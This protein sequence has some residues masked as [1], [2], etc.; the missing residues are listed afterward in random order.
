MVNDFPSLIPMIINIAKKAGSMIMPYFGNRTQ[1]EIRHKADNT[2]ITKADIISH[3]TVLKG[4]KKITPNI[5]LLSEEGDLPN[6]SV[7]KIWDEYW[8]CDPLDGTQG[9]LR[10]CEEFSVNIAL[11]QNH[12]SVL[13]VIYAPVFQ[14]LYYAYQGGG[15]FMQ[16]N[17]ND[18]IKIHT[19]PLHYS[20]LRV[21]IGR[22]HSTRKLAQLVGTFKNMQIIRLNSSLKFGY[23]AE[24][25]GD[26][27]LRYGPTGEWDTAAGQCILEEAGGLVVDLQGQ[28]LHYNQQ[29]TLVNPPFLA[30]GERKRVDEILSKI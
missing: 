20:N 11:V 26:V 5:P 3:E 16:L 4:L 27:Y 24:G 6:Y 9:F 29:D 14:M 12:K 17:D 22:Y 18:P 8:L 1:L 28:P 19:T 7:R 23:I 21:I 25:K 10:S 15:A 30:I 2:P 13:G